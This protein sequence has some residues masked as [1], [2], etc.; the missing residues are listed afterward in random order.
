MGLANLG[1]CGW[2]VHGSR[3]ALRIALLRKAAYG[4][5]ICAS[6]FEGVAYIWELC[7]IFYWT[8]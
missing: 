2:V 1:C 5:W 6:S 4:S 7:V 8:D 3:F